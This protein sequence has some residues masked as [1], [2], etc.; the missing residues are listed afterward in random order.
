MEGRG[1]EGHASGSRGH[2][3]D[4][5]GT[6]CAASGCAVR[7]LASAS[8]KPDDGVIWRTLFRRSS[9][10]LSLSLSLSH[11]LRPVLFS[12]IVVVADP[13]IP[14]TDRDIIRARAYCQYNCVSLLAVDAH[15]RANKC[16]FVKKM[17]KGREKERERKNERERERERER[18]GKRERERE[19]ERDGI[20]AFRETVTA[21]CDLRVGIIAARGYAILDILSGSLTAITRSDFISVGRQRRR[22]GEKERERERERER[23]ATRL[24][25]EIRGTR[26]TL[27]LDYHRRARDLDNATSSREKRRAALAI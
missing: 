11:E 21:N 4:P 17:K 3:G 15:G 6:P 23:D 18:E 24:L 12:F 26:R 19:R 25:V 2:R 8:A 22:E 27:T 16:A 5:C 1:D 20:A 10:S 13:L 14:R 7:D 9:D